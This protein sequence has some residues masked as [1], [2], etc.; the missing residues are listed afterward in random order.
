M[1]VPLTVQNPSI[2]S[3]QTLLISLS[4]ALRPRL[5]LLGVPGVLAGLG[6]RPSPFPVPWSQAAGRE[7]GL[8]TRC[9]F[10]GFGRMTVPAFGGRMALGPC[11]AQASPPASP[12]PGKVPPGR[13]LHQAN[14]TPLSP[15]QPQSPPASPGSCPRC[16]KPFAFSRE[17]AVPAP[18]ATSLSPGHGLAASPRDCQ[19]GQLLLKVGFDFRLLEEKPPCPFWLSSSLRPTV[20]LDCCSEN[21]ML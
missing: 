4:G 1:E 12:A 11:V 7:Q 8:P 17:V 21:N 13:C 2:T 5:P 20:V 19:E 3:R 6:S 18:C 14:L 9:A 16:E 10:P 15:P